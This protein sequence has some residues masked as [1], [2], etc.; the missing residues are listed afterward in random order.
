M[1]ERWG[2]HEVYTVFTNAR[3]GQIEADLFRYCI[4]HDRGGFYFDISKGLSAPLC[5]LLTAEGDG[6]IT[7][8]NIE[9]PID[10]GLPN[11]ERLLNPDKLI[12]QYGLG[13]VA[14]HLALSLVIDNVCKDYPFFRNKT[15]ASPKDAILS[16]TG[17]RMFTRSVR[18][19]VSRTADNG[20]IQVDVDFGGTTIWSM[21]GSSA[22]YWSAPAYKDA[23]NEVIVT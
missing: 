11:Y 8:E 3:F 5:G 10:P 17:P 7:Y 13:F 21:K 14:G 12:A 22:R 16:L 6:L 18:E 9:C 2:D 23:R 15:F 19:Y 20:L 1:F 4:L